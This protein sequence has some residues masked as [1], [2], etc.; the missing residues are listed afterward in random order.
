MHCFTMFITALCVICLTKLRW[1]KNKS[2]YDTVYFCLLSSHHVGCVLGEWGEQQDKA[3]SLYFLS[4][5]VPLGGDN[6]AA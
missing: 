5:S 3:F 1:P 4:L 2:L 6:M